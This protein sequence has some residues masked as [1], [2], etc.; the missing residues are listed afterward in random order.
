MK[1][2]T[3]AG[4]SLPPLRGKAAE[5]RMGGR[6]DVSKGGFHMDLLGQC[7]P[8]P[9]PCP[10]KGEGARELAHWVEEGVRS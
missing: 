1:W 10:T 3:A 8:P 2:I 4:L 9:E 5:G 7:D 6:A